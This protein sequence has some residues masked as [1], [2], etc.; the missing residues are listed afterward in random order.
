MPVNST[1][2]NEIF[3][4]PDVSVHSAIRPGNPASVPDFLK[5][6]T[7]K[8]AKPGA[9]GVGGTSV[10]APS[11]G[12]GNPTAAVAV[13]KAGS[14]FAEDLQI[15]EDDTDM[16]LD[17]QIPA[18]LTPQERPV[19]AAKLPAADFAATAQRQQE[20]QAQMAAARAPP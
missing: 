2:L 10:G 4:M 3:T 11:V 8:A 19:A 6:M 14:E 1:G 20:A 15:A 17:L 16:P 12:D 9:Q 18:M 7:M 5:I 13:A